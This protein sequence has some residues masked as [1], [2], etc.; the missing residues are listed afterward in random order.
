MLTEMSIRNVA[1][2]APFP[3]ET[4]MRFAGGVAGLDGVRL[5]G[6][7][8]EAPRGDAARVFDDVVRVEDALS[9]SDLVDGCRLLER[10]YG[11]IHR[12]VG[13][14]EP[15][16]VQLAEARELL[17]IAGTRPHVA[18]LFRDKSRMKQALW[19]A[20]LPTARHRLV[21]TLADAESFVQDVGFPIVM[22]PP[23]GMGA[24][25]TFRVDDPRALRD[26]LQAIRPSEA[27]PVLAEEWLA[28][29]ESSFETITVKGEPRFHSISEYL[30]SCL[31]VLENPWIQW[32]VLLPRDISGDAYD[33]PRALGLAAVR[34]LGL[35]DGFTHMEWFRRTDGSLAIGE[36]AQRPPG[37]HI[38]LMTGL[39]HGFDPYRAWARAVV[40]E[41]F[42]GPYERQYAV[43]CAYLRGM[44]RGRVAR[45][46][47][48]EEAQRAV[49]GMVEEFRL[50]S[51]GAHKS[52]SYEGDGYVVLR[53][54]D[55]DVVRRALTTLIETIRV[56]Y[57]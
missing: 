8:Q 41:A 26:A 17:G 46:R 13:I 21:T 6:V 12:L 14:L 28:G 34:A 47:G 51:V 23:A 4:T 15:L 48:V 20:G 44:G 18:E 22:K 30:P 2:A 1:F 45:V 56:D 9:T 11:P 35:D 7:M 25:A 3:L 39:A 55:D 16:Q 37:A 19:A 27:D 24:K 49:A 32:A 33:A 50:P 43:G 10:R 57:V 5:L 31:E 29:H 53:H 38:T 40:D 54:R 52:D 36:I 42:D